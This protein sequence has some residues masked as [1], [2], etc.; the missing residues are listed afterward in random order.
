[1]GT[2]SQPAFNR[3]GSHFMATG[4]FHEVFEPV[5]KNKVPVF[6]KKTAVAA[7]K[8]PVFK[9]RRRPFR[10]LVIPDKNTRLTV[11]DFTGRADAYLRPLMRRSDRLKMDLIIS[12]T[13][14]RPPFGGS[15][16]A[17]KG[18]IEGVVE[19]EGIRAEYRS[20]RI[21]DSGI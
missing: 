18:N 9:H 13:G 16:K 6:S 12:G 4:Q 3:L 10:V 11:I 21:T 1:M 20:G 5:R 17:F 19:P 15:I 2:G 7:V 14:E 8:P